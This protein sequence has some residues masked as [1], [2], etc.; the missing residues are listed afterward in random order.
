M[1]MAL[2]ETPIAVGV[3]VALLVLLG[4]A[5]MQRLARRGEDL[6]E[7]LGVYGGANV[8]APVANQKREKWLARRL[9]RTRP[10]MRLA[11]LLA[12]ADVP[13]KPG[14]FLLFICL[15]AGAGL[16]LG[17]WRINLLAGL[18]FAAV[19]GY[20][21]VM[22]VKRK[23]NKRCSSLVNQLPE[24]LTLVTGALRAGFG[25]AQALGVVV[26]EGP[27]PS[28]NEFGRVLRATSLGSSLPQALD[29][30]AKR[31]HSDDMDLLVTAINVQYEVGGNLT[32]ELE[33]ISH[34]IRERIRILREVRVLTSQQRMTG[35]VLAFLPI[36]LAVII[37]LMQPGYF[38]PF[39]EPGWPR[40]LPGVA[41]GMMFVAFVLIQK[42]LDIKV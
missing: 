24:V 23:R 8:A 12:Q 20:L 28:A 1:I 11:G 19:A 33:N 39:F 14:E 7:R 37:M 3:L 21:P 6:R 32:N 13:V 27:Q 2:L 36:G 17:T 5:F 29:D 41:L 9:G 35:Y 10:A 42:I 26:E 40:I 25:L 18:G 15:A 31:A 22:W 34:T 4:F 38:S 16:A 30:M